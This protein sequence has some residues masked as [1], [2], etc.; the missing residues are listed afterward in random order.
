MV[1]AKALLD[2]A[3]FLDTFRLLHR[4][5]GFDQKTAFT[6]AVRTYRGGGLTKDA[7]YLRGLLRV[8]K[9]LARGG[10]FEMLF[11]GKIAASHV[12]IAR[13]LMQRKVLKRAPTRPRYLENP[14]AQKRLEK[15]K[16]GGSVFDLLKGGTK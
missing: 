8:M 15:L 9:F 16:K 3:S 2:G 7:I 12:P 14:D 1:S 11:L 10:D 4:E 13:E 5:Y 6:V